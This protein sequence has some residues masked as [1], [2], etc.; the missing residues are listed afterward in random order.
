MSNLMRA[1]WLVSL[2][3]FVGGCSGID[4]TKTVRDKPEDPYHD[5]A[6]GLDNGELVWLT[7]DDGSIISGR[8]V[9]RTLNFLTIEDVEAPFERQDVQVRRIF[10]IETESWK[11]GTGID[12]TVEADDGPSTFAFVVGAV[13]IVGFVGAMIVGQRLRNTFDN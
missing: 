8:V 4:Q 7:M 5:T 10:I 11:V 1:F 3:F 2:L 9:T 6:N 12:P 13:L